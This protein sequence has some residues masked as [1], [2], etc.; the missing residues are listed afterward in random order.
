M[1]DLEQAEKIF[2]RD[3]P[4]IAL[5]Y[6]ETPRMVS[7]RVK[8]YFDNALDQHHSGDMWLDDTHP[9]G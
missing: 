1:Q 7:P 4:V 2:A 9:G 8:G 6:D 3:Q 5:S